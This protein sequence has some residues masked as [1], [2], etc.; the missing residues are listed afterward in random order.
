MDGAQDM[1]DRCKKETGENNPAVMNGCIHYIMDVLK[2]KP[3]SI[4][5]NYADSLSF[6]ADWY[7]QLWAE[8]LGKNGLGPTPVKATGVTDQHSQ[9]QLYMEG[10]NNKIITILGVD[11]FATK[12]AIPKNVLNEF[13]YFAGKDLGEVIH[14]EQKATT[15]ALQKAKRP[16]I[17]VTLSTISPHTLGQLLMMYQIQTAITGKLYGINPFDQPGVELGKKL[18]KE[19]LTSS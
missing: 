10:P 19:I 12:V 5:M 18:T 3:I 14:A 7:A 9:L 6:F 8:S 16:T 17:G 1:V 2:K 15:L 13:D 4:M 11:D